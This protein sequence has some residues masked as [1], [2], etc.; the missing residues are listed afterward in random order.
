MEY[1][2]AWDGLPACR[3][4][5]GLSWCGVIRVGVG[6]RSNRGIKLTALSRL[7]YCCRRLTVVIV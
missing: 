4:T 6:R 3:Q 1:N 7:D 5:G 2:I